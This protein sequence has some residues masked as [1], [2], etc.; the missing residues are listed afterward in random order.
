MLTSWDYCFAAPKERCCGAGTQSSDGY[1]LRAMDRA[2]SRMNA[3]ADG[4][5][6]GS[7]AQHAQPILNAYCDRELRA[8]VGGIP[9]VLG[10]SEELGRSL[11]S[12]DRAAYRHYAKVRPPRG[13][14]KPEFR[15]F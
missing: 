11:D 15:S 8:T 1:R 3:D 9:E 12:P 13:C 7:P 2:S 6:A 4:D 10:D 14:A 5:D